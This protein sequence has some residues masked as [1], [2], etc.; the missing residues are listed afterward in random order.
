M[1]TE[2]L[3]K[4]FLCGVIGSIGLFE[5]G[6]L[7]GVFLGMSVSGCSD[8]VLSLMA[9]SCVLYLIMLIRKRRIGFVKKDVNKAY[10]PGWARIIFFLTVVSQIYYISTAEM[11]VTPGEIMMETVSSF[12]ATDGIYI[13]SPLTGGAMVEMPLRY[14]ILCLPTVYTLLCRW[15]GGEQEMIVGRVVPV[16]VL[17]MTYVSYF[18]L[19]TVLFGREEAGREKRMWFLVIVAMIFWLCEGSVYME[20]YGI[21]HG[22]YSGTTIRN[23]ILVPLCLYGALDRKWYIPIICIL[24]EACIVWTFWG[25]G[26]CVVVLAGVILIDFLD[27]NGCVRRIFPGPVEKKGEVR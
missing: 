22:G 20:G 8:I 25:F 16:A 9:V 26:V 24:A 7:A 18:L 19:A 11:I 12:L 4:T 5:C 21:L 13:V 27:H 17:C 10:R 2:D 1:L 14:K 3:G 6:H 23:S 15:F